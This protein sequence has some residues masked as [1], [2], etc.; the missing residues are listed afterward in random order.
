[1]HV[2]QAVCHRRDAAKSIIGVSRVVSAAIY[3]DNFRPSFVIENLRGRCEI[4]ERA[5]ESWSGGACAPRNRTEL[6]CPQEYRFN[7][8]IGT[9]VAMSTRNGAE[10]SLV[11]RVFPAANCPVHRI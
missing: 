11:R 2:P 3:K 5:R 6:C 8:A 10:S 1:V 4:T 7:P 9:V